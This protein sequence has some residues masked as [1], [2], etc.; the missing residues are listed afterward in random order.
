MKTVAVLGANGFLGKIIKERL[1]KKYL[2]F[3]VSRNTLDITNY[4]QVSDWLEN[5]KPYAV[6]NCATAG[7]KERISDQSLDDVQNNLSIFLNFYNSS[8]YF[9]KFINVGSGAEFDKSKNINLAN[10]LDILTAEPKDSYGY[11]KNTISRLCLLNEK[12]YTLRLFGCFDNSEPDFRLF[13]KFLNGKV[14]ALE[15]KK[16]DYFSAKDYCTVVDY[17]LNNNL[18]DRDINCVYQKKYYLSEI[19]SQ[20][21]TV[22]V[23]STSP[24]N[25]TGNGSKLAQLDIELE[26]LQKAIKDYK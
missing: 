25:Y 19:L 9:E 15:D 23:T 21:G 14:T 3:S 1:S 7:G 18:T 11:S 13:K 20:L 5:L 16:F 12:F 2:I 26:G 22:N 24:I 10:E 6:I 17:V 8:Q 4:K